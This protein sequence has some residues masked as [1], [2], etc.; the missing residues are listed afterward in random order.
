MKYLKSLS[1]LKKLISFLAF[2][3]LFVNVS[4]QTNTIK[5]K[6]NLKHPVESI[7]LGYYVAGEN[8]SDVTK[9]IDGKF[10]F[11]REL[12]EPTWAILVVSYAPADTGKRGTV[13]RLPI[14]IE[15]GVM[16]INA[17]DSLKFAK[18]SGSKSQ[19]VY[20][21]YLKQREPYETK[22][23]NISDHLKNFRQ[24]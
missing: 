7:I 15:P 16:T 8:K 21:K 2:T 22:R 20:D 23:K 14:Y 1:E 17:K 9:L 3:F 4:G 24:E 11:S 10:S 19:K 6:L 12:T 18:I 5:G 13:E